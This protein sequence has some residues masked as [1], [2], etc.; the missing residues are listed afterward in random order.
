MK[1]HEF[2][3]QQV[4]GDIISPDTVSDQA[5]HYSDGVFHAFHSR[6]D[7]YIWFAFG[8]IDGDLGARATCVNANTGK[9]DT[10]KVNHLRTVIERYGQEHSMG[11]LLM[12]TIVAFVKSDGDLEHFKDLEDLSIMAVDSCFE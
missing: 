5:Y 10:S 11:E 2:I 4:C 8:I 9:C 3:G 6:K 7:H 12:K 1:F